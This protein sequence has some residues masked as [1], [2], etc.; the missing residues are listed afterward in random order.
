MGPNA[1][2]AAKNV[3]FRL[4]AITLIPLRG[5]DV[6]NQGP[7]IDTG[8]L[9]Q[10]IQF[11]ESILRR[12]HDPLGIGCLRDVGLHEP[13]YGLAAKAH[14][15]RLRRLDFGIADDDARPFLDEA[16]GDGGANAPRG[17]NQDSDPSL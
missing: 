4:T 10:D 13:G 15:R 14:H 8:I 12:F 11:P 6:L 7:G 9:D 2:F 1:A 17:P 5:I 16:L 3:P